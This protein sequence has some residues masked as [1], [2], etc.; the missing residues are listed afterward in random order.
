MISDTTKAAEERTRT[1]EGYLF[2]RINMS[3]KGVMGAIERTQRESKKQ[4]QR[5]HSDKEK[6]HKKRDK[7]A[8]SDGTFTIT[9]SEDDD[10]DDCV[11]RKDNS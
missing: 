11:F 3:S 8:D 10:D 9:T 4:R 6:G 1:I 7:R 5:L 2:H